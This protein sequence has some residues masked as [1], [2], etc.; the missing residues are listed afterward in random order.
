MRGRRQRKIVCR[1]HGH[2]RCE[3]DGECGSIQRVDEKR[4]VRDEVDEA[5]RAADDP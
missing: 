4:Q 5:L 3:L 2:G 1:R